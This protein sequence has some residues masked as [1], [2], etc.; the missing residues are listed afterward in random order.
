MPSGEDEYFPLSVTCNPGKFLSLSYFR[1]LNKLGD[2]PG[3]HGLWPVTS[4]IK[5]SLNWLQSDLD[6][7]TLW[8]LLQKSPPLLWGAEIVLN[9]IWK[10]S[11]LEHFVILRKKME[12]VM[13]ERS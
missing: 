6:L 12:Y 9:G 5:I 4:L 11:Y 2:C 13:N 10:D 1:G 3:C 8:D 7:L